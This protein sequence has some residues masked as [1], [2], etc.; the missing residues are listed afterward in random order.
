VEHRVST[1]QDHLIRFC[2]TLLTSVHHIPASLSSSSPDYLHVVWGRP[3]LSLQ[4]V[5]QRASTE[6]DHLI[7]FCATLL[8]S[9]HHIPAS[10]SSSSPD[11]LHSFGATK[12]FLAPGGASGLYRARPSHSVLCNSPGFCPS[13][14]R[15][16]EVL[17]T[18]P[19][20]CS[21]G[22]TNTCL[23]LGGAPGL[24]RARPSHS[25]LCHSPGFCPSHS[26]ILE[27]LFTRPPPCS[28]GATN[29]FLAPTRPSHSVLCNS[30][31]FC[32]S[33]SSS[34]LSGI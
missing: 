22:V 25:V 26:R 12:F 16:I 8:A 20:S 18:R 3:N 4:L 19:P 2:A 23:A 32:P 29:P 24:Y 5:E 15:I 30:P 17:F 28:L 10:L 9:V 27:F 31:G 13:H 6:K 34:A 21:L 11:H 7:R 14:S 33:S 1:E